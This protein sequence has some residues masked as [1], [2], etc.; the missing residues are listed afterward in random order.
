VLK[1]N[2]GD[3]TGALVKLFIEIP[4]LG[5][6]VRSQP[7]IDWLRT[8]ILSKL[9]PAPLKSPASLPWVKSGIGPLPEGLIYGNLMCP[10]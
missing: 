6:C 1:V 8:S 9:Y 10:Q 4:W 3:E 7:R 5:L 2:T